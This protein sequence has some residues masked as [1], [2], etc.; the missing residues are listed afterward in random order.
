MAFEGLQALS[1]L[2]REIPNEVKIVS[3]DDHY[4]FNL[5]RPKITAI[6]QPLE[7]ISEKLMESMLK[8]LDELEIDYIPKRVV[9]SNRLNER[10]SS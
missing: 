3:F 1:T 5:Y 8:H 10:E 9:L 6:E 2:E 7:L 4:F